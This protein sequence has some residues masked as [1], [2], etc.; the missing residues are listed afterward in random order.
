ME[1]YQNVKTRLSAQ[2]SPETVSRKT[3]KQSTKNNQADEIRRIQAE[4]DATKAQ[5]NDIQMTST[6]RVLPGDEDP[7]VKNTLENKTLDI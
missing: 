6:K 5:L 2:N 3:S 1:E 7:Q 4:L